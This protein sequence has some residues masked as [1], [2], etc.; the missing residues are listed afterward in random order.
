[1]V[2]SQYYCVFEGETFVIQADSKAVENRAT[3][4]RTTRAT[5]MKVVIGRQPNLG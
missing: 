5:Q 2:Y 1:M 3:T 4:A